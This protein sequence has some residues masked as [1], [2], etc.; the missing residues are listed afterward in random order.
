MKKFKLTNI[1]YKPVK[2]PEKN[3]FT[4]THKIYQSPTEILVEIMKIY[5]MILLLNLTFVENFLRE[6][7]SKKDTMK[8]VLE[9]TEYFMILL[10][11]I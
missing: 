8:F 11:K 5:N 2:P 9:F 3:F 10:I 6:S 4:I 7:I 1:S